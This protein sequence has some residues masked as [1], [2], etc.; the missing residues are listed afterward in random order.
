[1]QTVKTVL[2]H[3]PEKLAA[4]AG[5][6]GIASALDYPIQEVLNGRF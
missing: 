6:I 4:S 3:L 5:V 2:S 1:M